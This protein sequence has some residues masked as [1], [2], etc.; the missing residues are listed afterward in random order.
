M[1]GDDG[2]VGPPGAQGAGVGVS[3]ETIE[4]TSRFHLPSMPPHLAS[5]SLGASSRTK[6]KFSVSGWLKTS[7]L[8]EET[9]EGNINT[10][11]NQML[12]SA[13]P[14]PSH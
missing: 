6:G 2:R 11:D 10:V 8:E 5:R 13:S 12:H 4:V 7:T 9:I 14:A 1:N 3:K